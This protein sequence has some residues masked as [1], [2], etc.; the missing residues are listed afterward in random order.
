MLQIALVLTAALVGATWAQA[1]T[2][3]V[4]YYGKL[5]LAPFAC[6]DVEGGRMRRVILH[7]LMEELVTGELA[8]A[9]NDH[10]GPCARSS[11]QHG[12]RRQE[13]RLAD[14]IGAASHRG[15]RPSPMRRR[16]PMTETVAPAKLE[17]TTGPRA[18]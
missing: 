14:A 17:S 1:E 2:I 9:N 7:K 16:A 12:R 6:T 11:S 4:K 5:D 18:I 13:S 8:A 15:R 3:D 10:S